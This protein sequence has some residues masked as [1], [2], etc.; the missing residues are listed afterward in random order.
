MEGG[1]WVAGGWVGEKCGG[2]LGVWRR[3]RREG[4]VEEREK[5][6]VGI[7]GDQSKSG[8]RKQCSLLGCGYTT[9]F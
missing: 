2:W 7:L 4:V 5:V 6:A 9:T 3:G 8:C 1:W